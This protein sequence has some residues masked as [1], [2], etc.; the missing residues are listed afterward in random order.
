MS[1]PGAARRRS[2]AVGAALLAAAAVGVVGC[3][4][5]NGPTSGT[6]AAPSA[7]AG[8]AEHSQHAAHHGTSDPGKVTLYA[9]QTGELGVV[10]T[11]GNGRLLYRFDD[12]SSS[13]P[14]SHCTGEC[15]QTWL[16]VVLA[17]GQ[18]PDLLGVDPGN[19]GTVRRPDGSEQMTLAGWP[20]YVNKDDD[21]SLKEPAATATG[22][23]SAVTPSGDKAQ[24]GQ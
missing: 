12:D 2:R 16:P 18:Q 9:V 21:G 5:Q 15:A 17:N 4:S 8:A 24:Q 6:A 1:A 19:V 7:A 11:D 20:L 14:A 3:G 22:K 10:T 13:P 23:W